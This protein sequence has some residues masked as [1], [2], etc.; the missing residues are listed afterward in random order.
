[1]AAEQCGH[2]NRS[3]GVVE[4]D[5]SRTPGRAVYSVEVSVGVCEQCGHIEL[6]AK[7]HHALCDWLNNN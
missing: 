3:R 2:P 1:M 4:L 7:S 5:F 6:H